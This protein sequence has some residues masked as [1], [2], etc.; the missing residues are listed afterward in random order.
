MFTK[1]SDM[2]IFFIFSLSP[3]KQNWGKSIGKRKYDE[4]GWGGGLK[5]EKG[6]NYD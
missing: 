6:G 2:F 5:K 4:M 1:N 3:L